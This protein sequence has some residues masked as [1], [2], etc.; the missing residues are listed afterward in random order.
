MEGNISIDSSK[1][2][3]QDL[4]TLDSDVLP[5]SVDDGH[6]KLVYG[7]EGLPLDSIFLKLCGE[8]ETAKSLE[9]SSVPEVLEPHFLDFGFISNW[10]NCSLFLFKI[11]LKLTQPDSVTV[12]P[13]K[14]QLY[15]IQI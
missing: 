2:G 12:Q 4:S 7:L 5:F 3:S 6:S 9:D 8:D 1:E 13:F 11:E 10:R 15:Q 14:P